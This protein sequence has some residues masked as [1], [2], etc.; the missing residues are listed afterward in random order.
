MESTLEEKDFAYLII[1]P[2]FG[3]FN[4]IGVILSFFEDNE[5]F[6]YSE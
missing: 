3:I 5:P 6:D 4:F 2:V 1:F